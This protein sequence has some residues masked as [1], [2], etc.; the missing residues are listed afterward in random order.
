MVLPQKDSNSKK[1]VEIRGVQAKALYLFFVLK[2]KI[3]KLYLLDIIQ[4]SLRGTNLGVLSFC[5]KRTY[6]SGENRL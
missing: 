4:I 6:I 5:G 3:D 1:V 2:N